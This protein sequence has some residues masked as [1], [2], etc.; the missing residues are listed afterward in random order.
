[1]QKK[2]NPNKE[3]N[4]KNKPQQKSK[5]NQNNF[6]KQGKKSFSKS[7]NGSAKKY[8]KATNELPI[9]IAFLGGL[10]ESAKT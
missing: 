10:N 7:R 9:K 6:H 1:M 2:N 4:T 3:T 5:K 8:R